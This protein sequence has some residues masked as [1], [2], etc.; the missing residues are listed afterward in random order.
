MPDAHRTKADV[1]IGKCNPEEACPSPF[2]VFR[3]QFTHELVDPVPYGVIG[4]LVEC[5]PDQMPERM[6]PEYISA[7]K[8]DIQDQN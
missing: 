6:T 5:P 3:V 7:Q 4:E 1:D 2:L 8:D